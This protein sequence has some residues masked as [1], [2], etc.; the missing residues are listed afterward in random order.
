M[1]GIVY[2]GSD[3]KKYTA[4]AAISLKNMAEGMYV[5][6]EDSSLAARIL[7]PEHRTQDFMDKIRVMVSDPRKADLSV[8]T[9]WP[10][11]ILYQDGR[12]VGYT[13]RNLQRYLDSESI[14]ADKEHVYPMN[15][16]IL[17]GQN[18]C[19]ALSRLHRAGH[20]AGC[21]TPANIMVDSGTGMV[22]LAGA[23]DFQLRG[24]AGDRI[25][26]CTAWDPGYTAPEI[27]RRLSGNDTPAD[28]SLPVHTVETDLF[29]LGVNLFMLLMNGCHPY[30]CT[31]KDAGPGGGPVHVPLPDEN[32]RAGVSYIL[33]E[34]AVFGRPVNV[35]DYRMLP[36]K[37]RQLFYRC[38]IE[39]SDRP[40]VRPGI[41][42]WYDALEEMGGNLAQCRINPRHIY[43]AE[44]VSCPWCG[45]EQRTSTYK[46]AAGGSSAGGK[47]QG[48][49]TAVSGAAGKKA[50]AGSAADRRA[51]GGTSGPAGEK[52]DPGSAGA[53]KTEAVRG[54]TGRSG[55]DSGD[56]KEKPVKEPGKKKD[57]KKKN[58]IWIPLVL[59]LLALSGIAAFFI[60]TVPVPDVVG[61]PYEQ[62]MGVIESR[63]L[64]MVVGE[65]E[66]SDTVPNDAVISQ[67]KAGSRLPRN[68]EVMVV[69][70]KG[71]QALELSDYSGAAADDAVGWLEGDG[72]V[73]NR[74]YEYSEDI[75][76]GKVLYT[77]P[78]AGSV[79]VPGDTIDVYISGGSKYAS[80]PDFVGLTAEEARE[81]A[82][83]ND[84]NIVDAGEIYSDRSA[85]L[86]CAQMTDPGTSLERGASVYCYTSTGIV[87]SDGEL[88]SAD[89]T[90]VTISEGDT[91]VITLRI[92][93]D[94][95]YVSSYGNTNIDTLF[96]AWYE[97]EP[98]KLTISMT[99]SFEGTRLV[100]LRAYYGSDDSGDP[101]EIL[102]IYVTCE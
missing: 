99:G 49:K 24:P 14:L 70:S 51:A 74:K 4:G 31:S 45:A 94:C 27:L 57:R 19:A 23:E 2:T 92:S 17:M 39:G 53:G 9:A 90:H 65:E 84:L 15:S 67:T 52:T 37:I 21:L 11:V 1:T 8:Q 101:D 46:T 78:E 76:E 64:V 69:L 47:Q 75:P 7:S 96:G 60:L 73:V 89:N 71:P 91:A 86:I 93:S 50:G 3:G 35:P 5:I 63:G 10:E 62:A 29:A 88:L 68:G 36:R 82:A 20:L 61:M 33:E 34:N 54:K 32:I 16:R 80:V 97:G 56:G 44:N 18:L 79:V 87:S 26:R 48:E 102:N 55:T 12:S 72:F 59:L 41:R 42:E 40:E 98:V 38:F 81:L 28:L 77:D 66:F 58:R 43:P 25:Y 30:S 13:M 22:M 100:Q 83:D 6:A 85:G 95:N